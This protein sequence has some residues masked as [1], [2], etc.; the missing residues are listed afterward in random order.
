NGNPSS[1]SAGVSIKGSPTFRSLIIQS[2]ND[3]AHT[4]NFDDD[5]T[6][7]KLVTIGASTSNRL[8]INNIN[9]RIFILPTGSTTYGQNTNMTVQAVS[10][11]FYDDPDFNCYIG[12]N[13]ITN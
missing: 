4:V 12:S 9:D 7:T 6:V 1:E 13:S 10:N 11:I 5:V 8:A 3:K 2:K